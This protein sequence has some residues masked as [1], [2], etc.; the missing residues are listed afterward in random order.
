MNIDQLIFAMA[1]GALPFFLLGVKIGNVKGMRFAKARYDVGYKRGVSVGWNECYFERVAP[2]QPK[3]ARN[4]QFA[5][6]KDT[7]K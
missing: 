1:L 5:T 3:R 4:G 7:T 6:K 2:M